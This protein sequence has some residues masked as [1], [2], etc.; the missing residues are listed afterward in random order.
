MCACSARYISSWV[1]RLLPCCRGTRKRSEP[2]IERGEWVRSL[3]WRSSDTPHVWCTCAAQREPTC[4]QM[5][6]G[7]K[8]Q[9]LC[10]GLGAM[11]N[12]YLLSVAN[13]VRPYGGVV[14][15]H[16]QLHAWAA[17]CGMHGQLGV[18]DITS[19][20]FTCLMRNLHSR[21]QQLTRWLCSPDDGH[22]LLR[23][24]GP[25][26]SVL[27]DGCSM[28]HTQLG[29]CSF[30]TRPCSNEDHSRRWCTVPE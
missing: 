17:R 28:A 30:V 8:Q 29:C 5:L 14:G 7:C 19:Y 4:N 22:E 18:A 1:S 27:H 10:V 23:S 24:C 15:T 12:A 16:V 2:N 26:R 6:T 20:C 13:G 11:Q 3:C 9:V 21:T 25:M